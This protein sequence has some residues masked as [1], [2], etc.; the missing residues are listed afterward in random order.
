VQG[1]HTGDVIDVTVCQQNMYNVQA[2]AL[3]LPHDLV[4][5]ESGIDDQDAVRVTAAHQVAVFAEE[6]IG[7]RLDL[8]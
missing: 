8:D 6:R 5:L 4:D 3:D 1:R 7:N 2:V